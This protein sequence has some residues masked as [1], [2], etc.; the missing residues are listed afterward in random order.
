[1]KPIA[2]GSRYSND[3]EM[4]YSTGEVELLT[5]VWGMEKFRLLQ[6]GQKVILYTD[7]QALKPFIKTNRC[8]KLYS[9]HLLRWLDRLSHFDISVEHMVGSNLKFTNYLSRCHRHAGWLFAVKEYCC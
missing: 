2:I 8:N 1:M 4:K 9:A 6:Y 7:Y 5:M 3:T